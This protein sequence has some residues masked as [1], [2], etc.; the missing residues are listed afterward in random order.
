[1][2]LVCF[3]TGLN[4]C[5]SPSPQVLAIG[6]AIYGVESRPGRPGYLRAP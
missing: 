2:T 4:S 3:S 1:M 5:S 6:S